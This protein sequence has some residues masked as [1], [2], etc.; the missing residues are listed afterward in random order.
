MYVC[1][2]YDGNMYII[3]IVVHCTTHGDLQCTPGHV[4]LDCEPD[5][6]RKLIC[7]ADGSP[8][9]QTLFCLVCNRPTNHNH[10]SN[11]ISDKYDDVAE[12]AVEALSTKM[13][14]A[15]IEWYFIPLSR[16]Y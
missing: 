7:T 10:L 8:L 11:F 12:G 14:A 9:I 6:S 5:K 3:N 15:D 1:E 2:M 16:Q 4:L 13:A